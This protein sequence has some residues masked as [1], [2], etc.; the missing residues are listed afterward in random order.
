MP[1]SQSGDIFSS[2]MSLIIYGADI[3]GMKLMMSYSV[4]TSFR[5]LSRLSHGY[6]IFNGI[7]QYGKS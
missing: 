3:T 2:R 7:S 1:K 6:F 4:Q 5:P